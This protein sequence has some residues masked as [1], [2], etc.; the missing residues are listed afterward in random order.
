MS[1]SRNKKILLFIIVLF[2]VIILIA[3]GSTFAYFSSSISSEENA[4]SMKAAEFS[5]DF[6]DDTSLIK[7]NVIPSE[8]RFVDLAA[9]R[10]DANGFIKPYEENGNLVTANTACI[11]DNLNEICSI[12]SFTLSNNMTDTDLPLYITLDTTMN[13]FENLYFKVLDSSLNEVIGKTHLVDDRTYT[14][15]GNNEKVYDVNSVISPVV[16]SNINT[17]LSRAVDSEHPSS[18][19]YSIVIWIDETFENQNATDSGK[20]FTATLNASVS[21]SSNGRITGII[22]AAGTEG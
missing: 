18:V 1:E 8:E 14:L 4:I 7:G 6:S 11:D 17:T 12:Y 13:N 9:K 22:L 21:G 16:L 10:T 19:T 20:I 15:N 3:A 2:A 5:L